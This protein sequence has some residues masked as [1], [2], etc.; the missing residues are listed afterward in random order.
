MPLDMT[1][2][3]NLIISILT[4]VFWIGFY[5]GDFRALRSD[6]KAIRDAQVKQQEKIED[7]AQRIATMEGLM[8]RGGK[9]AAVKHFRNV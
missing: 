7:H 5:F 4:F 9:G 3:I 1:I 8:E 6:I 2:S